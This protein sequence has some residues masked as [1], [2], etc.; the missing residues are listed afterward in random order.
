MILLHRHIVV[1]VY[2][3]FSFLIKIKIC[4]FSLSGVA[5]LIAFTGILSTALVISVLTQKL[6]LTRWEK[7]VYNFVLNIELTKK[8]KHQS[9]NVVK[10]AIKVWYLR[11]RNKSTSMRCMTTQ[12]KLFQSINNLQN[13]KVQQRRLIDNCVV[14]ADLIV[15]QRDGDM[16]IERFIQNM[17]TME[18][19]VEN[20]NEKFQQMNFMMD[21]VQYKLNLILS[22][23]ST[24]R[25]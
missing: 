13:I 1:E 17:N 6:V 9:A 16:K 8:R 3:S 7:Y 19:T 14:L 11:R 2:G 5:A 4:L 20:L 23:M 10:Y 21:N 12:W 22:R 18:N 25:S 24:T 15:L